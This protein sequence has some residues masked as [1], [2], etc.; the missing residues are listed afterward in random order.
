MGTLRR[1]RPAVAW[2]ALAAGAAL[3]G[4]CADSPSAIDPQGP[5]A[6]SI[7]TLW[8][9]L[10]AIGA[11]VWIIVMVLLLLAV[12]RRR[13]E[14]APGQELP[15]P[16][17]LVLLGGAVLP[18]IVLVVMMFLIMHTLAGISKAGGP[19]DLTVEVIGHDWWWEIRYPDQGFTTANEIHIPVGEPVQ[20]KLS[21]ADVI[22]SFWVP[23]LQG[24]MDLIPGQT[25]TLWIQADKAGDYRGQCAEYCGLQHAH[26]AIHVIAEDSGKLDDWMTAQAKPAA[27]P[28]DAQALNGQQLFMGSACVYCHAIRGNGASGQLGPDLTHLASRGFIGA[29]V[30]ENNPENLGK[31]IEDPQHFKPGNYMP[32]TNL[33]NESLNALLSYLET[34]R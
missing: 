23:Q 20:L 19:N 1:F 31:W 29:G 3:L 28:A 5:R 33:D 8:W 15:E 18:A 24:K 26:M 34:L 13:R 12:F 10:L 32:P 4:G 9:V 2:V 6:S 22:H 27:Q 21:S 30:I 7:A 17:K 11:L 25:N 16:Q 14:P